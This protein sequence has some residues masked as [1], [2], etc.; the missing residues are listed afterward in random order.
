MASECY[1]VDRNGVWPKEKYRERPVWSARICYLSAEERVV[2][3]RK[4]EK[5]WRGVVSKRVRQATQQRKEE[6]ISN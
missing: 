5:Q 2:F 3:N 6:G 1:V 4:Y